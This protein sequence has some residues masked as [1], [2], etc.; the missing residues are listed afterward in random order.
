MRPAASLSTSFASSFGAVCFLV[1]LLCPALLAKAESNA[2]AALD[3]DTPAVK[4]DSVAFKDALD[5]IQDFSGANLH[6]NWAAL[7]AA[8]VTK[9][10]VVDIHIRG[11]PLRKVLSLILSEAAAGNTV[12]TYYVEDNV[13]EI[14]TLELSDK[15]LITCVYPVDDL[16][17]DVPD[18]K[19][20]N[21]SLSGG[22][23][24]ATSGAGGGG[25]GGGGGSGN[26]LGSS[27]ST[28]NNANSMNRA[29]KAQQLVDLITSIVRPEI[30]TTNGGTA[31]IRFFNGSLIITAPR[32][33]QEA[34]DGPID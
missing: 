1:A 23:A 2:R 9:D 29:Q 15:V 5:F 21:L 8:G 26:L 20:P 10:A 3:R 32:S 22:G 11:V 14:T 6:V 12:L 7:Q 28:S 27:S 16:V 33:V 34:I 13:I 24:T 30:W 25:G 17:L 18:F 31:S 19:A 4:L